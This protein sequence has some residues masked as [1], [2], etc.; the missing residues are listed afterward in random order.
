MDYSGKFKKNIGLF[1]CETSHFNNC[2]WPDKLNTMDE[3]WVT[4]KY[5]KKSCINSHVKKPIKI[6]G[7]PIDTGKFEQSYEKLNIQRDHFIFYFI[8]EMVRRKN[9]A[10]L[11]KA[12]H[13]EFDCEESVSLV[14]KS[15][16]PG[17]LPNE[18]KQRVKEFCTEIKKGLKLYQNIEQYKS[19]YII[20]DNITDEQIMQLH[21][22]CDC[23]VMPSYGEAWCIPAME[24][25]GMG[26][27]PIVTRNTGMTSFVSDVTG[28]WVNSR[29]EPV[30]GA[31]DTFGDLYVAN[32]TWLSINILELRSTMREAYS[33][34][35][36]RKQKSDA[37]AGKVYDFSYTKIGQRM[38]E[39][40][41]NG[42]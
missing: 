21:Y 22:S 25:M 40:L 36:L 41:T 37:G 33:N 26:K 16:V 23:F 3:I 4:N 8:G 35:K 27:T 2:L 24:A 10:A 11:I 29:Y 6:V 20:S 38:V 19:E 13:L 14:I 7:I 28:W 1:C 9:L 17:L 30:F 32:E 18:S 39:L 12:F 31:S 15:H 34:S 5:A 42:R